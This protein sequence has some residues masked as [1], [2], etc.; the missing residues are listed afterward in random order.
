MIIIVVAV[1]EHQCFVQCL[2]ESSSCKSVANT[3][4]YL[5]SATVMLLLI[6]FV[7]KA[8]PWRSCI[9]KYLYLP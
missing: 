7:L 6:A 5:L 3:C 2:T 4:H 9:A 1:V 8:V